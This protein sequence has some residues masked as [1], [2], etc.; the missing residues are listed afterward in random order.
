MGEVLRDFR[1]S[2]QIGISIT[3]E[4]KEIVTMTRLSTSNL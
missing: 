1:G 3:F 4:L 2:S